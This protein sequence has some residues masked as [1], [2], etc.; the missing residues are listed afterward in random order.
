[1]AF[2]FVHL[3]CFARKADKAGRSVSWV[4]DE[5]DRKP[6]AVP[7]VERPE[8][9]KVV[10]GCSIEEVRRRH[11]EAA[12]SARVTLANGRQRAVRSDQ[13]TLTTVVAS[14]PATME[15]L[16][17]DPKIRVDYEAWEAR[18]VAWLRGQ[19]GDDLVS[20][21]RHE[22]EK[23]PHVHGYI[24]PSDLRAA[25]LHPGAEAKRLVT[26]AGALPGED[27]KAVNRR[28]DKAYKGAMREW[29]DSYWMSVGLP[30][31]LTRLG[32]GRRRLSREEWKAEQAACASV[33]VAQDEAA[34]IH[35]QTV[36]Y[37]Q[38]TKAKAA[39]I[40][41]HVE[42]MKAEAVKQAEAAKTL[43]DTAEER[44]RNSRGLLSSAKSEA[45]RILEAA[46]SEAAQATTW[47]GR[48]RAFFDG[49]RRS[50]IEEAARR[51][52]AQE[53]AKERARVDELLRKVADESARRREAERKANDASASARS[54]GME[55]DQ[56]RRELAALRPKEPAV[57]MARGIT[58]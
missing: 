17:N 35:R 34:N 18:T 11:D 42:A 8:P 30:S 5:A 43:H 9:P 45:A 47:G 33:K 31:G 1:M 53:I 46:R 57:E 12:S 4:L 6:G 29:Q 52:A 21:V 48:I 10:Y 19:Y 50:S 40:A 54:I 26:E 24:M 49:L 23:H 2:Q 44:E 14:H 56:V 58:R 16:R 41:G 32:P 3:E 27:A 38:N 55:R 37:V 13:K 15:E 7:H 25:R 28:G 39:Q 22:D 36:Q 20:V 51:D